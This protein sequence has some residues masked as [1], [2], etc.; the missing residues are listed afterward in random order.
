MNMEIAEGNFRVKQYVCCNFRS[1]RS[2]QR[3]SYPAPRTFTIPLF[4][5][6]GDD[7]IWRHYFVDFRGQR[8]LG[9]L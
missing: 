8:G 9:N 7:L 6:H 2:Q 4:L 5:T 1:A 3:T